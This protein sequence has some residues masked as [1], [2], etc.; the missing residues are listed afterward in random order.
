MK[1]L[2]RDSDINSMPVYI[3]HWCPPLD[4]IMKNKN[5]EVPV[6]WDGLDRCE[7]NGFMLGS[8]GGWESLTA[9]DRR[10]FSRSTLTVPCSFIPSNTEYFKSLS[11]ALLARKNK[12]QL[13]MVHKAPAYT[14]VLISFIW[15]INN[16]VC[17]S[18]LCCSMLACLYSCLL[19]FSLAHLSYL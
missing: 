4:K 12:A 19:L 1:T 7:A 6:L 10:H 17:S 15:H 8:C 18:L 11:T 16:S 14:E 13:F 5:G 2:L 3:S 9:G